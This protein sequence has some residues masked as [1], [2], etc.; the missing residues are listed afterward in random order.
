M[1]LERPPADSAFLTAEKEVI[2]CCCLVTLIK[3]AYCRNKSKGKKRRT[4]RNVITAI[5]HQ[6]SPTKEM[7]SLTSAQ[8]CQGFSR[9]DDAM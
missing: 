7:Q 9:Q 1:K 3:L 2:G 6:N 8:G 5:K 4:D